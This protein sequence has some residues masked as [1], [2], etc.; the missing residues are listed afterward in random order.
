MSAVQLQFP[1]M[2]AKKLSLIMCL[3]GESARILSSQRKELGIKPWTVLDEVSY[4]LE[5]RQNPEKDP[6]TQWPIV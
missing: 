2:K 3:L 6:T 4:G 5:L 1:K